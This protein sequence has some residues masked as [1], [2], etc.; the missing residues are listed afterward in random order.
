[1]FENDFLRLTFNAV[2]IANLADD[3]DSGPLDTLYVSLHTSS[4]GE[5]GDQ[6]ENEA[7]YTGYERI[8]VARDN[9]GWTISGNEVN[10]AENI[11]FPQCSGGDPETI[12]H[13]AIGTAASGS[14]KVLYYGTVTPNIQV[15][16]GVTPILTTDTAITE[17]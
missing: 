5:A 15:S 7:E 11:E 2:G 8:G 3:A 16:N 13:F 1:M 9:T 17:D 6:E 4:P 12:T 14:G 10:P